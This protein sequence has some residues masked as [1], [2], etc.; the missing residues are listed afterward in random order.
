M[1]LKFE[2]LAACIC[3]TFLLLFISGSVFAQTRVNGTVTNAKDK[4]PVPYASVTV[5]GTNVTTATSPTGEFSIN[6]P[7]GSKS[8]IITSGGF[9]EVEVAIGSTVSVVMKER[10]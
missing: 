10:V 1:R 4:G 6:A 7:A 3:T 5:K 9:E 2:S 8:L